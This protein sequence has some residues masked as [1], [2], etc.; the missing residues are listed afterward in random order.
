MS[1]R[2]PTRDTKQR[3][4][5]INDFVDVDLRHLTPTE[6]VV[7]LLLWCDTKGNTAR[8]AR[9]YLARRAG[10]AKSTISRAI[11]SLTRRGLLKCIHKGNQKRGISVYTLLVGNQ[12]GYKK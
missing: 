1:K 2:R 5:Q 10:V 11:R 12:G 7:W 4:R 9:A 6:T 3:F 8:T